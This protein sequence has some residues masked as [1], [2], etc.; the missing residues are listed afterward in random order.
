MKK[1]AIQKIY[2]KHHSNDKKYGFVYGGDERGNL[3][4]KWIGNDKKILD[5]GCR[6]GSLTKYFADNNNVIGI[7]VDTLA[8]EE[9]EKKLK[10]K[11][12]FININNGLPFEENSFDIVVMGEVLEHT[13]SP[14]YILKEAYRVL[15]KKGILIGSV[16][17]AFRLKNRL[18]FL[19]G[20]TFDPDHT[21]LHW[22]SKKSLKSL[23]KNTNFNK[24]IIKPIAS[25]FLFLSPILFGN[26]LLWRCVKK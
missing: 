1:E 14:K 2:I 17:N 21:H 10:I 24:I 13:F 9:C 12:H 7:D 19:I 16:P 5:L 25:R 3:I 4:S 26:I 18:L 11:T 20:K 22:F 6:D 15:K 23:L 8:L